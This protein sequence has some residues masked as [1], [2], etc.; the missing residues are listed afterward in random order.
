MGFL[1]NLDPVNRTA[2]RGKPASSSQRRPHKPDASRQ[3]PRQPFKPDTSQQEPQ[4]A[5]T[6]A[7][8][9]KAPAPKE[10]AQPA[11]PTNPIDEGQGRINYGWVNPIPGQ[12]EVTQMG[13][14]GTPRTYRNG[15][16][17]GID[18]NAPGGTQ[19][20]AAQAGQ[21][22]FVGASSGAGGWKV[23]IDHGGGWE[24][25]YYHIQDNGF[26]VHQGDTVEAGQPIALVG[27]TGQT[28]VDHLH[29]EMSKDGK[30]VDPMRLGVLTG[31]ASFQGVS[32]ASYGL[33]QSIG[34]QAT[35]MNPLGA[36]PSAGPAQQRDE[37][38]NSARIM[39]STLI[40]EMSLQVA[41]GTRS[42]IASLRSLE[43]PE[44]ESQLQGVT[45]ADIGGVGT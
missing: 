9:P 14:F 32:D 39:L 8:R 4:A 43:T 17:D 30:A 7:S 16:H 10:V 25:R 18:L 23:T 42:P 44:L 35:G 6:S 38:R 19:M 34:E 13:H 1:P 3:V 12:T 2:K 21:I 15:V 20:V 31:E 27:Q 29:F 26:L 33:G 45:E 37:R 41:G 22:T 40:D 5:K 36:G 28:N 24:S 11:S